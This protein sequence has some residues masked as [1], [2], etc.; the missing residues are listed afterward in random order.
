SLFLSTANSYSGGTSFGT[1]SGLN[2]NNGNAFGTGAL[3]NAVSLSVIALPATDSAGAAFA[4]APMTITNAVQTYGAG[5]HQWVLTGV[6]AAPVTFSGPWTLT[7]PSGNTE[8]LD[9]RTLG[10]GTT[11]WTIS[12]PISGVGN[13]TKLN[14]ATLVLSGTNTYSG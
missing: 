11:V 4:V 12:G 6:A 5:N 1:G 9:C 3:T 14:T 10:S 2:I 13:I 7:Q 8:S